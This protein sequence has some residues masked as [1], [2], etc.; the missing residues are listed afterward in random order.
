MEVLLQCEST[1]ALPSTRNQ[2]GKT[3]L[4]EL[5]VIQKEIGKNHNISKHLT[6]KPLY[7]CNTSAGYYGIRDINKTPLDTI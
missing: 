3:I 4:S 7:Y 2:D 5:L 6:G 1:S